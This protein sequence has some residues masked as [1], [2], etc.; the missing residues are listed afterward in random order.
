MLDLQ[1]KFQRKNF[2][3]GSI[4]GVFTLGEATKKDLRLIQEKQE[5]LNMLKSDGIKAKDTFDRQTTFQ[6]AA[7]SYTK[8]QAIEQAR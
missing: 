7:L 5:C 1:Q 6:R 4:E 3:K 8:R 2:G